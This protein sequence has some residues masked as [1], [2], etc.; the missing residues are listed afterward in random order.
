MVSS[1]EVEILERINGV[2]TKDLRIY[3]FWIEV[4]MKLI[5]GI[6]LEKISGF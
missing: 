1:L 5:Y 6:Y 3:Y 4:D 2:I